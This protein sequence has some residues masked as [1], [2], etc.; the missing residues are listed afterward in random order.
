[1]NDIIVIKNV[2]S[3][4]NEITRVA[5]SHHFYKLDDHP[6]DSRTQI[7]W[8]GTKT[9]P[10][11]TIL[12][13]VLYENIIN[14]ILD[15]LPFKT[16]INRTVSMFHSFTETDISNESW[17]H[18]DNTLMGGVVYLNTVYPV[19]PFDHGTMI[20]DIVVPYEYNKLVL[21]PSSFKHRPMNG[22]GN[23]LE[24]SRLTLNFF[25]R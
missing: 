4:P 2:F 22:F 8:N 21:Y 7:T 3:F 13:P 23:S 17:L 14:Q 15:K 16:D 11:Q 9:L 6:L 18:N 24:T 20:N 5:K 12:S 1:V 10:L 25:I 19:N